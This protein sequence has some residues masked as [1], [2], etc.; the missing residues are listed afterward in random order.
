MHGL[1]NDFVVVDGRDVELHALELRALVR[2]ACDRNFGI[3]ADQF[4]LVSPLSELD[5]CADYS[6][7]IFNGQDGSE[8]EQCGN[9]ARCVALYVRHKFGGF[10][11]AGETVRLRTMLGISSLTLLADDEVRAALPPPEPP[12]PDVLLHGL[13]LVCVN[14]GNPHAVHFVADKNQQAD[15]MRSCAVAISTDPAF[16]NGV[17]FGCAVA[18]PADASIVLRVH[19]RGAGE[20]RACGSGA[21]AAVVAAARAHLLDVEAVARGI[22][23]VFPAGGPAGSSGVLLIAWAGEGAP[24]MMTGPGELVCEGTFFYHPPVAAD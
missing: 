15:C 19:E 1:G 3:G 18:M 24:V 2:A 21:C 6:Y 8:V 16:A 20:T 10:G 4:L 23:V 13:S 11:Q 7:R 17:N 22:R 9:G 14:L 12:A 5:E